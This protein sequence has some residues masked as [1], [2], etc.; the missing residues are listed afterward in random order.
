MNTTN[1]K[2]NNNDDNI[3]IDIKDTGILIFLFI[4]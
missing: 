2:D 1:Q 3:I 4:I